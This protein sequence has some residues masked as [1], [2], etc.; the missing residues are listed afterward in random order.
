MRSAALLP[1]AAPR[2]P[3][4]SALLAAVMEVKL[5]VALTTECESAS[6]TE[7]ALSA[8]G[9]ASFAGP[10]SGSR[11][12]GVPLP[13]PTPP[14]LVT[15]A[16]RVPA[17]RRPAPL[18]PA[19]P[20]RFLNENPFLL[21]PTPLLVTPPGAGSAVGSVATLLVP[22]AGAKG[23]SDMD[24]SEAVTAATCAACA[25][26]PDGV[27]PPA[28]GRAAFPSLL[29]VL[30]ASPLLRR[31]GV[32]CA[33][34]AA[35]RGGVVLAAPAAASLCKAYAPP[36]GGATP[37]VCTYTAGGAAVLLVGAGAGAATGTGWAAGTATEEET[38]RAL[39]TT[40]GAADEGGGTSAFF[41]PPNQPNMM[42][43]RMHA[44]HPARGRRCNE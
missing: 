4:A 12:K 27:P 31:G 19:V 9:D 1:A 13:M 42:H 28:L 8:C 21:P 22:G 43:G 39:P 5:E 32:V 34:A 6:P 30:V 35:V 15:P 10:S 24:A 41:F 37:L 23:E 11:P 7:E 2:L 33:S 17:G 16:K 29:G 44:A 3:A 38:G 26:M 14:T 18:L 25:D 20:P 36:A 40:D